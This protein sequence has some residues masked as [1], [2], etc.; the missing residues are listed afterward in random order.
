MKYFDIV[1][2]VDSKLGIGKNNQIPWKLPHDTSHFKEL[3]TT[4]NDANKQNAVI[5]GNNTYK[6]IGHLLPNRI[7]II[8]SSNCTSK[9]KDE[10][11]VANFQDAI[12]FA[13]KDYIENVFVIGGSSIYQEAVKSI[14][15]KNIYI[16]QIV[17]KNYDCDRFFPDLDYTQFQLVSSIPQYD[18][19]IF[20][21]FN[22][23]CN[24]TPINHDE[25]LYLDLMKHLIT[26][27][28]R[29]TRNG[30]T[31]SD[32]GKHLSFNI[33]ECFP[34]LTT[35][36]MFFRAIVEELL[37]FIRGQTDSKY[38]ENIGINIWKPNTTKEFLK[39]R[40]L[41][42]DEGDLGPMY[43]FIWR[44]YGAQYFGKNINY[45][46]VGHDQL[47]DVIDTII[48]DPNNRRIMMTTF[49]PTMVK[50]S[51]LAPCHSIVV[52]FYIDDNYLDCH[53]YQRSA[54][55]FL[56]VPFNIASTALL[57]YIIAHVTNHIPRMLYL[58]FGDTH[59]YQEHLN[60]VQ[61]QLARIPNPFPKLKIL[62]ET[63]SESTKD[64]LS[65]IES[66]QF[67]DFRLTD[68]QCHL[69]IKAQMIA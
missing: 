16:T 46:G 23:Y 43:G 39:S 34:L 44:H 55:M 20:Y 42:Y 40:N 14:Y 29:S 8:I 33:L 69:P 27:K 9:N 65:F 48:H 52:Q 7:N 47:Y 2:C 10:F 15:L 31:Y 18:N 57:T 56:G 26:Q 66:L 36:K 59:V 30:I 62:K 63:N 13:N 28:E 12:K 6:S 64:I 68:Y 61:T 58:S 22:H 1:V 49:D 54:D 38:L 5:M 21:V 51:V 41:N 67:S 35:K 25:Q 19:D 37:F 24:K 11:F 32:F 17:N 4:T 45:Q 53:M 60:A 50:H 3:T